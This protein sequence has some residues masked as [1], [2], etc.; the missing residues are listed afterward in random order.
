MKQI[1]RIGMVL[2]VLMVAVAI[3]RITTLRPHTA[4]R[5]MPHPAATAQV[6]ERT[7]SATQATATAIPAGGASVAGMKAA[8]STVARPTAIIRATKERAAI[9]SNGKEGQARLRTTAKFDAHGRQI[10]EQE[11]DATT[12]KPTSSDTYTYNA[13]GQKIEVA[14]TIDAGMDP[15]RNRFT[16]NAQGQVS[17]EES[18]LGKD[19]L[20]RIIYTNDQAGRP[21]RLL[22]YNSDGTFAIR[23]EKRY[24]A[25]GRCIAESE[26]GDERTTTPSST[27]TYTYDQQGHM[28]SMAM[29]SP[30]EDIHETVHY[31]YTFD[32]HGNWI[33]R[34]TIG[35]NTKQPTEVIYRDITYAR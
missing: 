9:F 18:Y 12:G 35:D 6:D 2:G 3:I 4:Q 30:A 26:F 29:T 15:V 34:T 25:Q 10:S 22:H 14:T 5:H 31:R 24:D 13:K 7:P 33:T 28:T 32:S 20:E 17:K 19:L 8:A 21:I 23:V 16:Y 27:I 1:L 11:W